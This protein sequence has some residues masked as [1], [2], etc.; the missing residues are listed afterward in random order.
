MGDTGREALFSLR[1]STNLEY[2]QAQTGLRRTKTT[3]SADTYR[4]RTHRVPSVLAGDEA[5]SP[6]AAA[7]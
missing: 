1:V 7:P 2:E 4:C 3:F 5:R 6:T